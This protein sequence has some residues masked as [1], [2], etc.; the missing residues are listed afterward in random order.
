MRPRLSTPP[1]PPPPAQLPCERHEH[2][3]VR[4]ACAGPRSESVLRV[5]LYWCINEHCRSHRCDKRL[6][7][8]SESALRVSESAVSPTPRAPAPC[9]WVRGSGAL[10]LLLGAGRVYSQND[11]GWCVRNSDYALGYLV[12]TLP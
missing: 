5:P 7:K 2:A 6:I 1:P 10:G 9:P 12:I 3:G 11:V 8:A 4:R